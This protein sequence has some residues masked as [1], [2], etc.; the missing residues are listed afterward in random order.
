MACVMC[1]I[2]PLSFLQIH[3]LKS[4]FEK[5]EG[6]IIIVVR[7]MEPLGSK[8]EVSCFRDELLRTL[9]KQDACI[10]S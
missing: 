4:S 9:L 8:C 5:E 1:I 3:D 6:K 10:T 2:Y 7:C